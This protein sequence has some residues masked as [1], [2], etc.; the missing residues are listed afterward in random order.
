[1]KY[2]LDTNTCIS[3]INKK[4]PQIREKF[5]DYA[6]GDIGISVITVAEM[7]YGVQK[8][9]PVAQ[10]SLALDQFLL[11]LQIVEFTQ[12]AAQVYGEIRAQLVK[13]G[14]PIGTLDTFIAAH[15]LQ[16]NLTVITNNVGEFS[17]VPGLRVENWVG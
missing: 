8:S 1:M 13:L 14:A 11:P 12:A 5:A 17:R 6:P 16:L 2:L 4:P 9:A 7:R 10:N 3:I 15:A